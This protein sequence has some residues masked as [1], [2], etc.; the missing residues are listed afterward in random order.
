MDK[1]IDSAA[2][3][4]GFSLSDFLTSRSFLHHSRCSLN[5]S[6][7]LP[8]LAALDLHFTIK[9]IYSKP[10]NLILKKGLSIAA[11][12]AGL[13][14]F[15]CSKERISGNGSTITETRNISGFTAITASGST[16][17]YITQG[18]AFKVEIKGYSNLLSYYETGLVNNTLQ[19]GYKQ[20]V[21]IKN[22]NIKVF[23]TLPVLNGLALS[24]SGSITTTGVFIGNTDFNATV[25][26]SGNIHF[27]NG[28]TQNFYSK[29]DGS[30]SIYTLNM[31]ADKAEATISGSGKIE[32]TAGNRLNVKIT[33][34]GK[35]YYRGTPVITTNITGSGAVLR[36]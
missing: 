20:N 18:T 4:T 10:L 2:S 32:I 31:V 34:S 15:S 16:N 21:N 24:G 35:V 5:L 1:Q 3:F 6:A 36:K 19:V 17:V 12:S 9:L 29:V 13:S 22:D 26:G 28:A 11:V 8:F 23:V 33:G 25:S 27:S 7:K 14:L 30:D